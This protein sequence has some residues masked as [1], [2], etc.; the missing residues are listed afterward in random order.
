MAAEG[1]PRLPPD[2]N[3]QSDVTQIIDA[4]ERGDAHASEQ[5]LPVVYQELRRLAASMLAQELPGQTLQA[6]ALVHEA[7]V[8]LV[9][10]DAAQKWKHRGHF[11][12]AAAE[13][14]RR[15]LVEKARRKQRVKHGGEH[16]RVELDDEHLV[17]SVPSDQIIAID[18]ALQRFA[19]EEPEKAQL[20]KLRF[21]AGL[22]LEE[23]AEALGISRATASRQWTYA[24][25]WLFN[26]L[27]A[28]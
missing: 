3:R 1:A 24:R 8:R 25:A 27:S 21:F 11:F 10:A 19:Q 9:H 4:I 14:M 16:D 7:Y 18:E 12:A 28:E 2:P 17:C 22:S 15:I 20:V 23:A 5:L 13:A 6:T 26:A